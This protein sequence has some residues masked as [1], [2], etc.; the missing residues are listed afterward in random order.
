MEKR[1][2]NVDDILDAI[3]EID[4]V[5]LAIPGSKNAM[6]E[7]SPFDLRQTLIKLPPLSPVQA[8]IKTELVH[9]NSDEPDN[10]TKEHYSVEVYAI[11]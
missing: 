1:L 11:N 5:F 3:A 8:S 10:P 2:N 9:A 4:D 6:V 7:V